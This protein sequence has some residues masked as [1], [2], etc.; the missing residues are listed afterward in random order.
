[1][2]LYQGVPLPKIKR[3][4][5]PKFAAGLCCASKCPETEGLESYLPD[6]DDRGPVMLCPSCLAATTAGITDAQV[7]TLGSLQLGAAMDYVRKEISDEEL[8]AK[9]A[10]SMAVALAPEFDLAVHASPAGMAERVAQA[11]PAV[12]PVRIEVDLAVTEAETV[13]AEVRTFVVSNNADLSLAAEVLAD[14]K[15][16]AKRVA[17]IKE[18]ATRPIN[19]ALKNIRAWFRP[20]EDRFAQIESMIKT[21]IS[22]FHEGQEIARRAALRQIE[23]SATAPQVQTAL[24]ALAVAQVEP[25][26]GLSTRKVWVHEIV[27]AA[28]VPREYCEPSDALIRA[29]VSLGAREIHGVRIYE[30]TIVSSRST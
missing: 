23:A 26:V 17:E 11:T 21:S 27:D 8:D 2:D 14:I 9:L 4:T 3:K 19:E 13:L 16:K 30:K 7:S 24:T 29:G 18:T 10:A 12:D 20:A 22:R 5:T 6:Y 1:M 28:L 25:V 15:G